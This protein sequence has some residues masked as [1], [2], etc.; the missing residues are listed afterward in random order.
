[1]RVVIAGGTGLLGSRLTR[2]LRADGIEV[3][4]L[5]RRPSRDG[6]RA[7]M[8]GSADNEWRDAVES[9]DVVVNLAGESIAG[10]R[11]SAARKAAIR[12]SRVRATRAL[13]AAIGG[14]RRPPVFVSGSAVG[15]YGPRGDEV[16]DE[17]TPPGSD[18]LAGV[19]RDWEREALEAARVT[20][21]VLLRTGLVLAREGGALP[22]LARPIRLFVGGPL[23]PGTQVMP[24][25]H[26]E[27]WVRLVRWAAARHEVSGPLNLTAP[28]PVTNR[29]M[30]ATLGRVL[31]RPAILP[32][33][34]FALRIILG[35]MADALLLSGQRAVPAKALR[36][37]FE[38]RHPELEPALRHIYGRDAPPAQ[39]RRGGPDT[40]VSAACRAEHRRQAAE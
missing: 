25:I 15:I 27:D 30:V 22:P 1:M 10:G 37:G 12:D 3:T 5:T 34:A 20:R 28:R 33:P 7:W 29:E 36:L 40:N 31:R 19:G 26:V 24:W 32:A 17:E 35:E 9:A 11:W 6:E 14:A 4:I 2:A 23:G 21:V 18:F 39:A 8:P 16:V 13:A 38:F